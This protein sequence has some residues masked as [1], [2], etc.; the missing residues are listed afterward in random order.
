MAGTPLETHLI[1]LIRADG[2][3]TISRYMA[4]CLMHPEYGYYRHGMPLGTEGDFTTAPEISQMFGELAGLWLADRWQAA[5]APAPFILAELGPGRGSL[6][7][8]LLRAIRILPGMAEA[9]RLHLVEANADLKN[10]QAERLAH[11]PASPTWHER[12]ADV[13]GGPLFLVANEFFD[14]LPVHQF[15]RTA[16]GWAERMVGERDGKLVPGL[17]PPGPAFAL[18]DEG[19]KEK[20]RTGD[21]MEVCPT[22]ISLAG[23]IAG[24]IEACGGAALIIDY[25]YDKPGAGDTLQAVR[26]HEYV[27]ILDSPG[28]ADLTAH[29]DFT[30]IARAGRKKGCAAHGPVTQGDFLLSLGIR[31]RADRLKA[32]KPE[33][34]RKDIDNTVHRLTHRDGMGELF[35]VLAI[36]ADADNAGPVP[37]FPHRGGRV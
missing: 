30:A 20:A 29:V 36:T 8:D 34:T 24:R 32:G 14:A 4:E 22:A 13:P 15:E 10:A 19:R 3:L 9:A 35:R 12:L 27:P 26:G 7:A 37:G 31:E 33:N 5:G 2:P 21:V 23:E 18:L 17:G 11:S 16:E 1:S 28:Q 6:M 25:G